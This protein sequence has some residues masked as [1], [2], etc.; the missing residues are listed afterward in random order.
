MV[1]ILPDQIMALDAWIAQQR[2][3]RSRPEAIRRLLE[4][5][6]KSNQSKQVEKARGL[7]RPPPKSR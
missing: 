1:R 3:H 7:K 6:L 2:E 5:A 4:Q